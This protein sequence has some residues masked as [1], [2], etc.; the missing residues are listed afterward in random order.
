MEE[1][2]TISISDPNSEFAAKYP[3][4]LSLTDL[5]PFYEDVAQNKPIQLEWKFP[6][7]V[8]RPTPEGKSHFLLLITLESSKFEINDTH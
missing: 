5:I 1:S 3:N 4:G 8:K 6:G 2:S 7:R